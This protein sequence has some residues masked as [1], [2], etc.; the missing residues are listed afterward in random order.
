MWIQQTNSIRLILKTGYLIYWRMKKFLK[1]WKHTP[2]AQPTRSCIW[3][4]SLEGWTCLKTWK[5][6]VNWCCHWKD[7]NECKMWYPTSAGN[8]YSGTA[9]ES[10]LRHGQ[11]GEKPS[12]PVWLSVSQKVVL[13]KCVLCF[14]PPK[15]ECIK[16][17]QIQ[18]FK[19]EFAWY[20]IG[21]IFF[22][23]S[24]LWR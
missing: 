22:C 7:K 8:S 9:F 10:I 18:F 11:G 12:S 17:L 24:A 4:G 14:V 20:P 19:K 21:D 15:I 13:N 2:I 5:K 23:L 1:D 6:M 16:H 3:K